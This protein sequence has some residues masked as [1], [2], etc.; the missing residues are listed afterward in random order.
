MHIMYVF[1]L[2]AVF[3]ILFW[4]VEPYLNVVCFMNKK[5]SRK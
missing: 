1:F 2:N 3:V 4:R 5:N